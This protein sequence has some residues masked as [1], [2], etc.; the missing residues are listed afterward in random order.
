M[1]DM[2]VNF[3]S[4][5][6]TMKNGKVGHFASQDNQATFLHSGDAPPLQ[7]VNRRRGMVGIARHPA[8]RGISDPPQN[9]VAFV[10]E[11][12]DAVIVTFSYI[13][14]VPVVVAASVATSIGHYTLGRRYLQTPVTL[15]E[16]P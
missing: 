2:F 10:T 8:K 1:G 14:I 3:V 16:K 15:V 6:N 4:H 11:V 9:L 12:G 7:P 13:H 5:K